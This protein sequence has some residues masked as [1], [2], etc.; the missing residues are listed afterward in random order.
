MFTLVE[1]HGKH[2][3]RNVAKKM[4][5]HTIL[6]NRA[7]KANP[8]PCISQFAFCQRK[9]IAVSARW[10]SRAESDSKLCKFACARSREPFLQPYRAG[11][12][13]SKLAMI[14][15]W[16]RTWNCGI[17]G[18][19]NKIVINEECG[20]GMFR[21]KIFWGGRASANLWKYLCDAA[22]RT[23]FGCMVRLNCLHCAN[24]RS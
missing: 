6:H 10:W 1:S 18:G 21:G 14:R 23:S 13:P 16:L 19:E 2:V 15:R 8:L 11:A 5:F 4:I 20:T 24:A 7:G 3:D 12:M 22:V 17:V 9:Q